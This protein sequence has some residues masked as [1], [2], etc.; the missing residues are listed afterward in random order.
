MSP[1]DETPAEG[2]RARC[3]KTEQGLGLVEADVQDLGSRLLAL[4]LQRVAPHYVVALY[5]LA[6]FLLGLFVGRS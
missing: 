5:V 6:A 2:I 4:E 1:E 3:L